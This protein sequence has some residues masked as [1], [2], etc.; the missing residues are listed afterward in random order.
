MHLSAFVKTFNAFKCIFGEEIAAMFFDRLKATC[1]QRNIDL[2]PFITGLGYSS[3]NLG[4]WRN[5]ATPNGRVICDI[6][7]AL[8]V[9]A[10]YLLERTD[11]PTPANGSIRRLDADETALIDQVRAAHPAA[12]RTILHMAQAA[13]ASMQPAD[14]MPTPTAAFSPPKDRIVYHGQRKKRQP[15]KRVLGSAAAGSP[16]TAVPEDDMHISVPAKYLDERYFIVRAQGDSMIEAHIDSGDYCVFDSQAHIDDGAI[17][18]AQ[19]EGVT[20]EFDVAIKR[21]Y[22][23]GNRVELRSANPAYPPMFFSA[24]SVSIGGVLAAILST[25][26]EAT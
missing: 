3:G 1:D 17:V 18:F 11:D 2:T 9:S 16:I 6:A 12:R 26:E 4:K 21:L 5:G 8:N 10:D 14:S 24:E 25:T 15:L 19:V 23:H 22:R 20:D 13:L 7:D